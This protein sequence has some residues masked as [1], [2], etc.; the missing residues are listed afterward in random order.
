M[1]MGQ[2]DNAANA[3]GQTA[4]PLVHG[5]NHGTPYGANGSA[6]QPDPALEWPYVLKPRWVHD[7][8]LLWRRKQSY[9]IFLERVTDYTV[10]E[11]RDPVLRRRCVLWIAHHFAPKRGASTLTQN[12]WASYSHH[13]RARHLAAAYLAHLT[14]CEPLARHATAAL[15]GKITPGTALGR[16]QLSHLAT[17]PGALEAWLRTLYQWDVLVADPRQGGYIVDKSLSLPVQTFPLLV[18]VWWLEARQSSITPEE[19]D[20]LP[21]W[22]WI[23][24]DGF[25][26]GWQAYAGRLW[27]LERAGGATTLFLH[28]TDP[29]AFTRALLNLLS[30]DGRSGRQLPRRDLLDDDLDDSQSGAEAEAVD[31]RQGILG[32]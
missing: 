8:L 13:F 26:A 15:H 19:F 6:N 22:S 32:R 23:A 20:H 24:T 30:T 10:R 12:V 3:T 28:P 16:A 31:L 17:A 7:L 9:E 2:L 11:I 5:T 4:R 25:A 1:M 21:L 29:A 14:C 27:T 18:W